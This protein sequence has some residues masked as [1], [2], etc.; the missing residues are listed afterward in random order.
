MI[1][2]RQFNLGAAG[3]I[4]AGTSPLSE[5]LT[6]AELALVEVGRDPGPAAHRAQNVGAQSHP[7]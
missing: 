7:A 2:R 5:T 1:T 6:P 3:T 4:A